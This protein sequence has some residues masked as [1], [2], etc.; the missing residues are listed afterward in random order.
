MSADGQMAADASEI[1]RGLSPLEVVSDGFITATSEPSRLYLPRRGPG[2]SM[3]GGRSWSGGI[4]ASTAGS[5]VP[6]TAGGL[7]RV[8]VVWGSSV[9]IA[10]PV[11]Q[12]MQ[13]K[14]NREQWV[15]SYR[16][17]ATAQ[18]VHNHGIQLQSASAIAA[19]GN[20]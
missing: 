13:H 16:Y 8:V 7:R 20:T 18:F 9:G 2:T 11:H 6:A 3:G 10:R 15:I 5:V 12:Q 19:G 14:G 17:S 1:L 4:M